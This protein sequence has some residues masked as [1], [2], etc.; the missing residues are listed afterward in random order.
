MVK[1]G[2]ICEGDTEQILLLSDKFQRFLISINLLLVN[3]IN[4]SGSGNL[5]PHNTQGYVQSLEKAEAEI[6]FIL[7]DLDN[8]VCITK[9]KERIQ[10]RE[11]DVVIIAVKKIEAWFLASV[12]AMRSLLNSPDFSYFAPKKNRNLLKL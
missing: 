10:A 7:T 5:L 1:I 4:A 12:F 11:K 6:I 2:F 9:T 8:D 3:V